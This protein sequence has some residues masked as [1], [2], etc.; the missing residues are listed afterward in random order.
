MKKDMKKRM[1]KQMLAVLLA[2]VMT[3]GNI[4]PTVIA[5][6]D[7][8]VTESVEL[9]KEIL[10][11]ET[12]ETSVSEEQS[13]E[14]MSMQKDETGE[15]ISEPE[16]GTVEDTSEPEDGTVEDT[17]EPENGTGEDTSEPEDGTG[18]E[19]S[20]PEAGTT[21]ETPVPEDGTGEEMP[22]PEDGRGEEIS[23]P[24]VGDIEE[25]PV[26][27]DEN[28]VEDPEEIKC[29]CGTEEENALFHSWG[30]PVFQESFLELCDCDED[31]E[32]FT[33]H[34]YECLGVLKAF[35]VLCNDGCGAYENQAAAHS[36]EVQ[37]RLIEALCTCGI[38]ADDFS[39]H[40]ENCEYYQYMSGSVNE[41]YGIS[42]SAIT[43]KQSGTRINSSS[44][45]DWS[46]NSGPYSSDY[47]AVLYRK[48]I[49]S[50][51]S[52]ADSGA[53][54]TTWTNNTGE[55]CI[56]MHPNDDSSSTKNHFGALYSK[57]V[58]DGSKWYDMKVTV[59]NYSNSVMA[60]DGTNVTVRP[61]IKFSKSRIAFYTNQKIGGLRVKVEFL[62]SGTNNGAKLNVRF[63]WWDI[64]DSQR[65]GFSTTNTSGTS[66]AV[67][68][69]K[70]YKSNSTVVNRSYETVLGARMEVLT[71][72]LDQLD[73][74]RAE[75]QVV[76]E[77]S[78]CSAYFMTFGPE[79]NIGDSYHQYVYTA[80]FYRACE[81]AMKKGRN[82]VTADRDGDGT[83]ETTYTI[84]D[85]L[86]VTDASG[87]IGTPAPVKHVSNDG[88]SWS[89]SNTLSSAAGEYYYQITQEVPWQDDAYRYESFTVKDILPAGA[90]YVSLQ[91][92][93]DEGGRDRN[94]L[95]HVNA[96]N[97]VLTIT[98][99]NPSDSDFA[100]HWYR[101]TVKVKMD[102]TEVTP[103]C[104]GNT[105]TYQIKNTASVVSKNA[106]ITQS[107]KETNTVTTTYSSE[108]PTQEEP[109]KGINKKENLTDYIMSDV[110]EKVVFSIFQKVP[111]YNV[112]WDPCTITMTD[113]L[114]D[115][116]EYQGCTVSMDGKTL[117]TGWNTSVKGQT[118][119]VTGKNSSA[120][121]EKT[122]RFD[123][124]CKV[125]AGYDLSYWQRMENGDIAAIIPNYAKVKFSW[126]N[127]ADVEKTTNAVHIRLKENAVNLI[128][129]KTGKDTGE[130]IPGAVFRVY[131]WDG[132]GYNIQRGTMSYNASKKEY[133]MEQ[134]VRTDT[135]AGKFKV[136]ESGIP[137]GYTGSW[138]K[139]FTVAKVSGGGT[140]ELTYDVTNSLQRCRF[141]VY[142]ENEAR[143][144]LSGAVF[145]IKA[146]NDIVS[147]Q[148]T[149]LVKKGTVVETLTTDQNGKA[150]SRELYKGDYVI[151]EVKAPDGYVTGVPDGVHAG[152]EYSVVF[153]Y[154]PGTRLDT[155]ENK[156]VTFINAMKAVHLRLTKEIDTADIVW[157]HGNPTFLFKVEGTDLCGNTHMYYEAVEFTRNNV[158][159]SGKAVL[160][161][162]LTMPAGI[163]QATE[164]KTIRYQL[165]SIREVIGGKL[166]GKN[167][168]SFDLS[169][170]IDGAATF[171][172]VKTTDEDLSQ[173]VLVRNVMKR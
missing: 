58:Y 43:E 30:C 126:P 18:E 33:D 77:L 158:N 83:A 71:G 114:E 113:T 124:T 137:Y 167:A 119:T 85:L 147:P 96:D 75:A 155:V 99:K 60:S 123:I 76:F 80:A 143:N 53:D 45:K 62:E 61:G 41:L 154:T 134:L 88:S 73:D 148:G 162:E 136:E 86:V 160:T 149:V 2:A 47:R 13:A 156:E 141:T 35:A 50:V 165:D 125:K 28:M 91:S 127:S 74:N 132:K 65:F 144:R 164:E 8:A 110:S 22:V 104:N 39:E 116:L 128:I 145:E 17:S 46:Y 109:K 69:H 44:V 102:P 54:V 112:L 59:V 5:A 142:K 68:D 166:I 9:E 63:Q 131:E 130:N 67:L 42:P 111:V 51:S 52:W 29:T 72:P 97:D 129:H 23:E 121:G 100:G 24:E 117:S 171:Y 115:C 84:N 16:D 103:S 20:E 105:A 173:T 157:A 82:T 138:E 106:G 90:D 89:T 70:Y 66:Y 107:T 4:S 21:E 153:L 48:G 14:E 78:S 12:E 38:D 163:Y 146:G 168:V 55:E 31:S 93:L 151:T 56:S 135:N 49:S 108:R 140:K 170:G 19:I 161:A 98:A 7:S 120:Y 1:K 152:E 36:C 37:N 169:K 172:N 118:V 150:V 159:G 101:F 6:S 25:I 64:D 92:V 139:E 34:A 133:Q 11:D 79:D 122:L 3:A 87:L 95:F 15:E 32:K 27:E 10:S 94:G 81:E 57:V 26:P 40:E